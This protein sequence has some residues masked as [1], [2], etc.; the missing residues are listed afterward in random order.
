V[1]KN[2]E[3]EDG[4]KEAAETPFLTGIPERPTLLVDFI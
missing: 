1:S 3:K 2:I 4:E